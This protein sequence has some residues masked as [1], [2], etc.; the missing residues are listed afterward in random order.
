[1]M[2]HLFGNSC[3]LD[4]TARYITYIVDKTQFCVW[5]GRDYQKTC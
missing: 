4:R 1:L 5:A 2:T 3:C